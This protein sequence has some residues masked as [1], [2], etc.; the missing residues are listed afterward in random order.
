MKKWIALALVLAAVF[1]LASCGKNAKEQNME[2]AAAKTVVFTNN[3]QDANIWILPET[4]ENLETS[5]WGTA[6]AA[7]VKTGESRSVG[8]GEPS[9]GGTYIFRMID[10]DEVFY[11][12][13][14]LILEDGWSLQI[15]GADFYSITIEV[16]NEA[17]EVVGT[18]DVFA[19]SL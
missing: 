16:S 17:G 18:Y 9:D 8:I 5:L 11:S 15:A 13:D 7:D 4:K 6:S 12:A 2:K 14:G 10:A 19:A 3:I 1:A